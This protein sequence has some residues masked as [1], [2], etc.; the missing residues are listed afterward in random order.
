MRAIAT[1]AVVFYHAGG[2]GN[3]IV[4]SVVKISLNWCVPIFIMITGAL[5]LDSPKEQTE[6]I[7]L[8]KTL[9]RILGVLIIFGGIYN[10]ISLI[11]INGLSFTSVLIALKMV[12]CADTTF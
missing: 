5:F 11:I 7:I 2:G 10:L 4:N 9:P 12:I 6:K 8:S 1:I 3:H